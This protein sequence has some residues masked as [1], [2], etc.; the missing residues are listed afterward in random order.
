MIFFFFSL[1]MSTSRAEDEELFLFQ[2]ENA[3]FVIWIHVFIP[4]RVVKVQIF[5]W[6]DISCRAHAFLTSDFYALHRT[7]FQGRPTQYNEYNPSTFFSLAFHEVQT[8]CTTLSSFHVYGRQIPAIAGISP[9]SRTAG[10]GRALLC[11]TAAFASLF[12]SMSKRLCRIS[13]NSS[14]LTLFMGGPQV[15][16]TRKSQ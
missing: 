2:F 4:L 6:S 14:I 12:R 10:P 13:E 3:Y 15:E 8:C 16:G 9:S 11:A 1:K 5:N 7:N